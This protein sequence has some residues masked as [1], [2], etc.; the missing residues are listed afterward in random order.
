MRTRATLFSA[1]LRSSSCSEMK[2]T[3]YTFTEHCT[4][5]VIALR[6]FALLS[7]SGSLSE[8]V[9]T[10]LLLLASTGVAGADLRASPFVGGANSCSASIS[11][12][13][14]HFCTCFA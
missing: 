7:A 13:S 3:P 1:W 9:V 11:S 14:P 12:S 4:I 5:V 8:V 6:A 10:L 2:M